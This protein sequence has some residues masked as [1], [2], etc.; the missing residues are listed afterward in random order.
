MELSTVVV[1]GGRG[2]QGP[3]AGVNVAVELSSTY[4]IGGDLAYGRD[5][6]ATWNAL[7][8]VLGALEGGDAVVF[9]SG[10]A[11]IS[12]VLETQPVGARIVVPSD[13][14]MGTRLFLDD[15]A[16][17]GRLTWVATD[18]TDVEGTL[19]KCVGAA[20]LW[21]E[22]PTNPMMAVADL[23][24]LCAGARQAGALAV[25]D[26]TFATPLLQRPLDLGADVVVHSVTKYLS[27]HSDAI[28]GVAVARRSDLVD[29]LRRRRSMH[30]G[31]PGP[32]EAY[33]A[34]RGL[35]TLAVRMDR[36]QANAAEL[37]RRLADHPMVEVVR[38]PGL[39][40]DPGHDLAARQMNGFGAML[41]FEVGGGGEGADAVCSRVKVCTPA[42][43]LGGVETLIERR[44][45]WEGEENTPPGL[46]RLSVGIEDIEDLWSDLDA[47]LNG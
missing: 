10:M 39:P 25:V 41:S 30:G 23:A 27:G 40:T 29:A 7:E 17:R 37:A 12:S 42:T 44:N 20:L 38:Y 33:L 28:M 19:R 43:S 1:A 22:S 2:P 16:S 8:E 4:R 34:L 15:L 21:M 46:L 35:R 24:C 47:A 13:S 14:Y 9:S 36:S 11:A 31:I 5:G 45:R 3:G 26:N 6:N 32:M 18:L